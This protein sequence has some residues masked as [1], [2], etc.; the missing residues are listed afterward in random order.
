MKNRRILITGGAGFIG[1]HLCDHLI[2]ASNNHL[3]VVDNFDPFYPRK[4]KEQNVAA[5]INM[6]NFEMFEANI[7]DCTAMEEIVKET[8]PTAIV[9]LAAKA[10][11]RNSIGSPDEYIGNNIQGTTNLLRLAAGHD[12]RDFVFVSSSSVYGERPPMTVCETD[13]SDSPI[14]PYAATKKACE[15]L[16]HSY[17]DL[18]SLRVACVRLFTVYGPRQRPDLAISQFTQGLLEGKPITLFGDGTSSRDYTYV[19]DTVQGIVG[20]LDWL[21]ESDKGV[22]EIF[23]L[24]SGR[25]VTL[26]E[27]LRILEEVTGCRAD[28][29]W[30]ET[31]AGDVSHTSAA[32]G[33]A[34][35]LFG[36]KPAKELRH[37]LKEFVNWLRETQ[38]IGLVSGAHSFDRRGQFATQ[39]SESRLIT[40]LNSAKRRAGQERAVR[41][42]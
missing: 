20:S 26:I 4:L 11:V 22:F 17:H 16:C 13:P 42:H 10:G 12:I 33:K 32:I 23:N 21:G 14:S 24:G 15:L 37:G 30:T 3:I 40:V 2:R 19:A 31:Q 29:R 34:R 41:E 1:S 35:E 25:A 27:L 28:I 9:H 5:L 6:P 39:F 18:Y 7:L 36:Y 8:A 38:Q